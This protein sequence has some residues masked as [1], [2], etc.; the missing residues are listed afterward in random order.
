[1]F[2]LKTD[3]WFAY[4]K[5]LESYLPEGQREKIICV[6]LLLLEGAEGR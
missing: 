5:Q 4:C 2:Y 3:E 1:M 6:I